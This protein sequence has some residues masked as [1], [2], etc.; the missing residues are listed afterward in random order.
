MLTEDIVGNDAEDSPRLNKRQEEDKRKQET[1][2]G[3][4]ESKKGWEDQEE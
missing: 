2:A 1:C 4:R 3:E